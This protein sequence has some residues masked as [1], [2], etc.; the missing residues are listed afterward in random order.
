MGVVMLSEMKQGEYGRIVSVGNYGDIR[1]RF[2]DLGLTFGSE[3]RCILE[4]D[5]GIKAYSLRGAVIA[6]RSKDSKYIQ[7]EV[8][9]RE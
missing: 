9:G 8:L 3:V 6:I 2:I 5:G 4:G 1:R 7:V